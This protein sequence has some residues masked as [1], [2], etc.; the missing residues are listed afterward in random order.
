MKLGH[1]SGLLES[2]FFIFVGFC[3][4]FLNERCSI[5]VRSIFRISSLLN[6]SCSES[7]A[8]KTDSWFDFPQKVIGLHHAQRLS[9]F[10][11]K[12][13]Q[14]RAGL[15]HILVGA[16][17]CKAPGLTKCLVTEIYVQ[18]CLDRVIFRTA[19]D[20]VGPN[21]SVDTQFVFRRFK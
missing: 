2:F 16:H 20:V 10:Q 12:F 8:H 3:C 4:L 9:N 21:G 17:Y 11:I 18:Q 1:L 14:L 5:I 15:R 6:D 7:S 19:K 13:H